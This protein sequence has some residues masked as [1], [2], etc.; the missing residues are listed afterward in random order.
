VLFFHYPP[1]G[2]YSDLWTEKEKAA[3]GRAVAGRRVVAVFC[4]HW[5]GSSHTVWNGLDGYNVGSPKH[6][7]RSFAVVRVKGGRFAVA[8]FD[9][10]TGAFR[11]A[12]RSLQRPVADL[13]GQTAG[14]R[15]P[16]GSPPRALRSVC[17]AAG[18]GNPDR[19]T[20]GGVTA[21]CPS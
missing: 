11:H 12:P 21:E 8:L 3:F 9:Q 7:D 20:A 6:S 17:L 1:C 19:G 18:T 2:P 10:E 16:R 15:S 14:L 4:G 5:H 13:H